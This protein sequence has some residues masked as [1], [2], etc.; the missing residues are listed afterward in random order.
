MTPLVGSAAA[1]GPI[2]YTVTV[3][4]SGGSPGATTVDDQIGLNPDVSADAYTATETGG[5]SGFTSSGELSIDDDLSLPAL[6]QVVYTINATILSSA[7]GTLTNTATLEPPSQSYPT[8]A[9]TDT[10]IL[11]S[12]SNVP[13]FTSSGTGPVAYPTVPAVPSDVCF[14]EVMAV[15]GG[16]GSTFYGSGGA[17]GSTN[18]RVSVTPGEQLAVEVGGAGGNVPP[19]S[20]GGTGGTGGGGGGGFGSGGGGGASVVSSSAGAPLVVSGGGGGASASGGGNGGDSDGNGGGGG[21]GGTS[22]GIGGAGGGSGGSGGNT[23]N[24]GGGGNGGTAGGTGGT[25]TG[26]GGAGALYHG[27]AGGAGTGT[28]GNGGIGVSFGG[29]GGGGGIGFG[30]GGGGAAD[31]EN[32][33]AGGGG[34]GFGGGGGGAADGDGGGGGSSYVFPAATSHSFDPTN[35][36]GNGLVTIT[37]DPVTDTCPFSISTTSLPS[38]TPGVPYGPVILQTVGLGVS[39]PTYTTTLKWKKVV[40]PKGLK[41]SSA[42][43]LSGTPNKKLAAGPSSATVQVTETVTTLNGKKKV[44]TKTTVQATIPLNI[45]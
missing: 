40:L 18:A 19:A 14:V 31:G 28:G 6:S 33:G 44:K 24:G 2:T 37:Y 32:A 27:G 11:T 26:T 21:A 13:L 38:A 3:T 36:W 5:A 25:G 29:G 45:T 16:G 8:I 12:A 9:A 34:G 39:A 42:G 15:G 7:A 17:G 1:G 10:D 22:S 43:V 35:T 4:N 23:T 30:G 20:T 41:L